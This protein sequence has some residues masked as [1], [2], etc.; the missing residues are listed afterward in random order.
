ML[1]ELADLGVKLGI[2]DYGT[3]YSSLQYLH[4]LPVNELKIDRSFVTNLPNEESNRI[5]VRSSIQMAHSLGLYVI[6]EGAEDELTCAM[7]AEAECDFIQ[8]YYLS[9]PQK[10]TTSRAWLLR[11]AKLEFTPLHR[12][13]HRGFRA[14]SVEPGQRQGSGPVDH[15]RAPGL[16]EAGDPRSA[17]SRPGHGQVEVL[18]NPVKP[19]SRKIQPPF[20]SPRSA[21]NSSILCLR[22]ARENANS[23]QTGWSLDNPRATVGCRLV[24]KRT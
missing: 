19:N 16:R 3:G 15:W 2:D 10:R 11:G 22:R 7:L 23:H 13:C 21:S 24:A 6:A 4:K 18:G 14:R 5:I 1:Y 17:R 9:K 12:G 8:G 20:S